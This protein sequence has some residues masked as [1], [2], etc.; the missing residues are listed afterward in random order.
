MVRDAEE[1]IPN[2]LY[3]CNAQDPR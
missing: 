1:V 3:H 2:Y